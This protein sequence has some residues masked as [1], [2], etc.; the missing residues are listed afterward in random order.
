MKKIIS[1]ILA[2]KV[3]WL[4]LFLLQQVISF[5]HDCSS[6]GDCEETAGYNAAVAIVGGAIAL[7]SGIV[8]S[9]FATPPPD[10]ILP[11]DT[12]PDQEKPIT[13]TSDEDDDL[14]V[15]EDEDDLQVEDEEEKR[16]EEERIKKEFEAKR[17]KEIQ[18]QKEIREKALQKLKEIEKERKRRQDYINRL[19]KKYDTTPD[20]LREVL[21]KNI[22]MNA[23]E[24][25]KWNS[26]EKKLAIAQ[27]AAEYTVAIADTSIDALAQVTGP[28]GK[29]IRAGYKVL[30]SVGSTMADKGVN[31][32]SL[33][34]GIVTGGGDAATDFINNGYVKAGVTI[35]TQTLGGAITDGKKG[36]VDGFVK[37]VFTAGANAG[38]DKLGGS[39]YGNEMKPTVFNK[40]GTAI[41][42]IKSGGEWIS[43]KISGGNA[44][45][46]MNNKIKKLGKQTVVNAIN[47][48]G[49]KPALGV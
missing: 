49:V 28:A 42:T 39:G 7:V 13:D 29:G 6:P 24:A 30:K 46:F 18:K 14:V 34:S 40:D 3:F 25:E 11:D 2:S 8:G 47:N 4:F 45:K 15:E 22:K 44:I 43:K 23:A 26:Y 17:Q 5:A 19:C 20:K 33:A 21:R 35:G 36:A 27:K 31:V 12:I 37:G 48:L 16:M 9:S 41:V 10:T 32:K 1:N 38:A